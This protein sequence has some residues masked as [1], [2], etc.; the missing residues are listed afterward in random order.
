MARQC[1]DLRRKTGARRGQGETGTMRLV[2]W[3]ARKRKIETGDGR[4]IAYIDTDTPGSAVVLIH[5][6]TDSSLS[7]ALLEPY[8]PNVR[9]IMPDLRGHGASHRPDD[10]YRLADFAEDIACLMDGLGLREAFVVGH[11]LGASTAM[12]LA[13]TRPELVGALAVI[14]GTLR[15]NTDENDPIC[16]AMAMLRDPIDPAHE[17][18]ATWHACASPV[19]A[20]FL[21]ML[22]R[23]AAAIPARLW[24]RI[25]QEIRSCDLRGIASRIQQPALIVHGSADPL[26]SVSQ[27]YA[28]RAYLRSGDMIE[29]PGCGHNPHWERPGRVAGSLQGFLARHLRQSASRSIAG[30]FE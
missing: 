8:L 15:P 23:D 17:F 7:F 6:F 12:Q 28:L 22:A 9:L 20:A 3:D 14:S 19:D 29:L 16:A 2:D 27:A 18:F 24:S 1:N 25:F 10:A 21:T 30:L 13:A 4:T 11:S 26:F 5:G